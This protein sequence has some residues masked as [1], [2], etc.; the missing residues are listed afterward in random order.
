MVKS[1]KV[2]AAASVDLFE[3]VHS[4][5]AIVVLQWPRL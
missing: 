5:A 4:P 2:M 1:V 3:D